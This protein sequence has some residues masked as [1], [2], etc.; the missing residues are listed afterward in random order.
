MSKDDGVRMLHLREETMTN[1]GLGDDGYQVVADEGNGMPA[2]P[3]A[4]AH[5]TS[6]TSPESPSSPTAPR[7]RRRL[8]LDLLS[9]IPSPPPIS[10]RVASLQPTEFPPLPQAPIIATTA[11]STLE[12][13]PLSTAFPVP[14]PPL[15]PA[16]TSSS[17]LLP[18]H[19]PLATRRALQS[20][21][22][23][24][25]V[26]AAAEPSPGRS[27][28][29]AS[30][31]P[32]YLQALPIH[33]PLPPPSPAEQPVRSPLTPQ[34]LRL[35]FPTLGPAGEISVT[36]PNAISRKRQ[37]GSSR[38][39]R[40]LVELRQKLKLTRRKE[41]GEPNDLEP[42][43][44]PPELE[45]SSCAIPLVINDST[46]TT[47]GGVGVAPV[48]EFQAIGD[49]GATRFPSPPNPPGNE[50]LEE[51]TQMLAPTT[52]PPHPGL[53]VQ[54]GKASYVDDQQLIPPERGFHSDPL[55]P[56]V[57]TL[58]EQDSTSQPQPPHPHT[59]DFTP[60]TGHQF[61]SILVETMEG[62]QD[63]TPASIHANESETNL[64]GIA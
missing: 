60:S 12:D 7:P 45:P 3:M 11:P 32:Q 34:S 61:A 42:V 14:F 54:G 51:G 38:V 8:S 31:S 2:D 17:V 55:P 4:Q 43:V 26:A 30:I 63:A 15:S 41:S 56:P 33:T 47:L 5:P 16:E 39:D 52:V 35:H 24:A 22:L 9:L 59:A 18:I 19:Q 25:N 50:T 10:Q 6:P 40:D 36:E 20:K 27:E 37:V 21:G 48:D 13:V 23:T 29:S 57:A 62:S 64:V 49:T 46:S 58:E 53:S 44:E 1:D 28:V